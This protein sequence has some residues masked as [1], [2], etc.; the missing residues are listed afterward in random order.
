M[1]GRAERT[2]GLRGV[3][4]CVCSVVQSGSDGIAAGGMVGVEADPG[5]SPSSCPFPLLG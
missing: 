5:A 3:R 4:F 2:T 1:R